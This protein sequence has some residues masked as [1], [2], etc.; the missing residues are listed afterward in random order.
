[1][2]KRIE[3]LFCSTGAHAGFADTAPQIAGLEQWDAE[4][5]VRLLMTG[6]DP[7][8]HRPRPPM[9]QYRMNHTDAVAVVEYLRSLK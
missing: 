9:P 8:G 1:M 6:L 5:A 2:V 7:T 4:N 3:A